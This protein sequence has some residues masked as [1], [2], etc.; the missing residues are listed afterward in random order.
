MIDKDNLEEIRKEIDKLA[1]TKKKIIIKGKSIEF[2]RKILENKKVNVLVMS[3]TEKRDKLRQRDSGL[4]QVL[5]KIAKENNIT[6]AFD[7]SEIENL[8]KKDKALLLARFIQNIKLCK[9]YK[10]KFILISDKKDKNSLF[11][12]LLT[13]GCDTKNAK[14]AL[15]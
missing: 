10:T 15:N 8:S 6:I 14:E 12:F 5:C 2:N 9:K 3:H 7:F 11:S 4:N 1:K 13:L